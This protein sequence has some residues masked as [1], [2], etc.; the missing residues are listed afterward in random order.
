VLEESNLGF[1]DEGSHVDER[2]DAIGDD[3]SR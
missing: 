1:A 2:W 3:G